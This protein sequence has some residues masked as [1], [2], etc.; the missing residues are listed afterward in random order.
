MKQ[1]ILIKDLLHPTNDYVFKRIFGENEDSDILA[2]L[3]GA[4]LNKEVTEVVVRE[5]KI[6]ADKLGGKEMKLDIKATL[7]DQTKV[8]IEMQVQN[9]YNMIE[10]VSCYTFKRFLEEFKS[11]GKYQDL[12]QVI[13]INFLDYTMFTDRKNFIHVAEPMIRADLYDGVEPHGESYQIYYIELQKFRAGKIDF[14]LKLHRWL[15][16]IKKDINHTELE[17]IAKM[18]EKIQKAANK[19]YQISANDEERELAE[20]RAKYWSDYNSDMHG[21]HEEGVEQG[22]EQGVEQGIEQGIEQVARKMLSLGHDFNTISAATGLS[23]KEV[24]SFQ[25]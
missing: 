15:S 16:M 5:E 11:G 24:S 23:I 3:I 21:A 7:G 19:L 12:K 17:E 6:T 1:D 10:R 2:D 8:N 14:N 22:I 13:S 9:P 20:I 4:V 25:K 18:D